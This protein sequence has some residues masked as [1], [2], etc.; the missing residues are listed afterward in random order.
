MKITMTTIELAD[1]HPAVLAAAHQIAEKQ[2]EPLGE[3]EPPRCCPQCDEPLPEEAQ[4][5]LG[6]DYDEMCEDCELEHINPSEW[7]RRHSKDAR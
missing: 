7:A 3:D 1:D 4:S 2:A 6:P 5:P